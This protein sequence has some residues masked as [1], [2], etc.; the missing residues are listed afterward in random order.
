MI[1]AEI[2]NGNV[3]V[4]LKGDTREIATELSAAIA[5]VMDD[6]SDSLRNGFTIEKHMAVV[7]FTA[8][9]LMKNPFDKD[10]FAAAVAEICKKAEN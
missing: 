7:V 3:G 6:T 1:K 4:E 8:V 10:K 2:K 5:S 9:S